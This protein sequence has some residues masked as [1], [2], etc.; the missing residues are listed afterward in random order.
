MIWLASYPRSGNSF[1]RNVLY[2]VYGLESSTFHREEAYPVDPNYAEFPIIKTH[3][4]PQQLE[5]VDTSIPAVYLVRD[6]RDALV[7]LAHHRKDIME[8]GT[9]FRENLYEAIMAEEGSYFGGWS[10]NVMQWLERAAVTIRFEDLINDPLAAAQRLGE[11]MQLPEANAAKLPTFEQLKHGTPQ[12]GSGKHFFSDQDQSKAMAANWFRRGKTGAWK[13]EMPEDLHDLFWREH[14]E[15][16]NKL[17][18]SYD[19]G[20][21]QAHGEVSWATIKAESIEY[22]KDR[23]KYRVLVE[24]SKLMMAYNDGVKRYLVELLKEMIPIVEHPDSAWEIDLYLA[25]DIIPLLAFKDRLVP[26]ELNGNG[27]EDEPQLKAAFAQRSKDVVKKL[28]PTKTYNQLA[29]KY[30]ESGLKYKLHVLKSNAVQAIASGKLAQQL[31]EY[32]LVHLPLPQHFEPFKRIKMRYITTIHDLT[33]KLFPEYHVE[34]NIALAEQGMAFIKEMQSDIIAISESTRA[35]FLKYWPHPEEKIHAVSE[36]AD[37]DVFKLTHKNEHLVNLTYEKYGIPKE[38]YILCLSTLEPRKN[39][40]NTILAFK[41]LIHENPSIDLNLVIAGKNGWKS[42]ELF[43]D[44]ELKCP[45][46]YFTGFVAESFLPVLYSEA[47]ALC[48]ASFYEGFGL[49]LIEAMSCRT[50]VLYGNN[51]SMIEVAGKGGLPVEPAD[52][53]S[54][55][56]Q[57]L[58]IATDD[59]LR[60]EL[61]RQAFKQAVRFSWRKTA[62]GTLEAYQKAIEAPETL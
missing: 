56:E 60:E 46:I 34:R 38:P 17:G 5:P 7:S 44:P 28:V 24:A 12:Y 18:Y 33:H 31:K 49:P 11:V 8:P 32:D 35:D 45:R 54:I 10:N 52:I 36:A 37:K 47:M 41:K 16:M 39:L 19:G 20:N 59:A 2:E 27:E 30:R 1:L 29:L 51:S 48:Y 3:L 4:L 9:D 21:E 57:M 43:R 14:G 61:T 15:V 42:N 23:P 40:R 25:G 50:P 58:R 22:R 55:K 62:L 53:E 13:D 26:E 6:G